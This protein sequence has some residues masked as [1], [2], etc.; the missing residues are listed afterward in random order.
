MKKCSLMYGKILILSLILMLCVACQS[1]ESVPKKSSKV[2]EPLSGDEI[3]RREAEESMLEVTP[4]PTS[5]ALDA[6]I[7]NGEITGYLKGD[8]M[9]LVWKYV[10][11]TF[12]AP[13][14]MLGGVIGN[15]G[16]IV[17]ELNED[18]TWLFTSKNEICE[19]H[20]LGN[21]IF[22]TYNNTDGI[23]KKTTD[24]Y[25]G[26]CIEG[27]GCGINIYNA[28]TN[29]V[30]ILW[31]TNCNSGDLFFS[32]KALNNIYEGFSD[33]VIVTTE[34]YTNSITWERG[35]YIQLIFDDGTVKR[36]PIYKKGD[37]FY[38]SHYYMVG[39][40][41]E[42]MFFYDR[43]FYDINGECMIDCSEH[44]IRCDFENIPMFKDGKCCLQIYKN[45]KLWDVYI[46]ASGNFISPPVEHVDY[47]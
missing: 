8:E 27:L 7:E 29:E 4:K 11:S 35:I 39:K 47:R 6:M 2:S 10:P 25:G 38:D 1:D 9:N 31:A 17:V 3:A 16:K 13:A 40:Y 12:D 26:T 28:K 32:S 22:C 46:D 20:H 36:T 18:N 33:G 45:E 37:Y 41:S 24:E 42:G 34:G 30:S 21:D 5:T 23:Y 19:I 44:A 14:K 43:K 15:D